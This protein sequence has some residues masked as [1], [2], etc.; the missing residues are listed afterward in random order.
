MAWV[1]G[2]PTK[3]LDI[4]EEPG[5]WVEIKKLPWPVLDAAREVRTKTVLANARAMGAE[6]WQSLRAPVSS[7]DQAA[8]DVLGVQ[9][10]ADESVIEAAYRALSRK[11]HPDAAGNAE[12]MVRLNDAR[13]RILAV[14]RAKPE[15][16]ADVREAMADT[17]NEF[18]TSYLLR[19][20]VASWSYP[21]DLPDGVD[22]IDE[23]TQE[24][25]KREV[26]T[27][28]SRKKT[29]AERLDSSSPSISV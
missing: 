3:R 7:A 15:E 22:G 5:E 18:D 28:N 27:F 11:V 23:A 21:G 29:D 6:L 14:L 12:E 17:T 20:A 1:A 25:L 9:P 4:P 26:V 2:Q 13:D 24:W 19:H 8:Y 10:G 16:R